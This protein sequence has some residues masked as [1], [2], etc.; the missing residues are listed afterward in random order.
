M[1]YLYRSGL[2]EWLLETAETIAQRARVHKVRFDRFISNTD[3][4]K[5]FRDLGYIKD[6][7][8]PEEGVRDG[9]PFKPAIEILT[10]RVVSATSARGALKEQS[11]S[12][13]NSTV[14]S[15]SKDTGSTD[16][17]SK[18][19]K[20]WALAPSESADLVVASFEIEVTAGVSCYGVDND[21]IID[22]AVDNVRTFLE[23]QEDNAS[24]KGW[25][26]TSCKVNYRHPSC[27]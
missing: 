2:K 18:R 1:P 10:K 13:I 20:T 3:G 5:L 17:G 12:E 11:A 21:Y 6:A 22:K 16:T 24:R 8:S 27:M 23:K 14:W 26:L 25:A 7:S 15:K 9:K 4:S 19:A